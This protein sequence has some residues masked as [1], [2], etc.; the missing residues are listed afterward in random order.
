M[1]KK[2]STKPNNEPKVTITMTP[3]EQALAARVAVVDNSW[4][5]IREEDIDDFSLSEDRFKLPPEAKTKLARFAFRW[6]EETPERLDEVRNSPSPLT[7]W[8]AN[9]TNT[10]FLAKYCDMATGAVRREG[11]VLVFKPRWMFEM[12]QGK[13]RELADA[14]VGAGVLAGKDGRKDVVGNSG[15]STAEFTTGKD[16]KIGSSDIVEQEEGV[17]FGEVDEDISGIEDIT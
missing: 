10:P 14:R 8:I 15:A 4:K 6:V 2:V 12:V 3:N 16:V 17:T 1:P 13:K 9:S 5:T 11:Q 7:W